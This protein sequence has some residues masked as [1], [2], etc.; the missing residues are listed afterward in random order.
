ME[1]L[2]VLLK[3]FRFRVARLESEETTRRLILE[4]GIRDVSR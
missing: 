4:V 1:V 3:T 2:P